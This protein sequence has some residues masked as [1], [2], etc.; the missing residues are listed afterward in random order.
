MEPRQQ[1]PS[2]TEKLMN[3]S[4]PT[5][6]RTIHVHGLKIQNALEDL[7][8]ICFGPLTFVMF[9]IIKCLLQPHSPYII[10]NL[11]CPVTGGEVTGNRSDGWG[12]GTQRGGGQRRGLCGGD[13]TEGWGIRIAGGGKVYNGSV[14]V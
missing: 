3:R 4:I 9:I 7:A 12:E 6:E 1:P 10:T 13:S 5:V 14:R 8:P 11:A 2:N